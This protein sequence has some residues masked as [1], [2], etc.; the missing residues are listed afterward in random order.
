MLKPIIMAM[1]LVESSN[2][3]LAVS[4]KGAKG[5]MQLMPIGAK[6]V[7][8]ISD[9]RCKRLFDPKTNVECGTTLFDFYLKRSKGSIRKALILYNSGYYGLRA[10]KLPRE[11]RDY[12]AKVCA[13]TNCETVLESSI[14]G[15]YWI[16]QPNPL[17]RIP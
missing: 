3:P 2:N 7:E 8:R 15:P 12:L 16:D 10:R 17:R 9:L 5:L 11:T 13:L 4:P 6:E 14:W 1:I